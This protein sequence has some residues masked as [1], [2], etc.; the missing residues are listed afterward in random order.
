MCSIRLRRQNVERS[1]L[2]MSAWQLPD[3]KSSS[4]W[5]FSHQPGS[6]RSYV[7]SITSTLLLSWCREYSAKL[8]T[9]QS[10]LHPA[11]PSARV[12]PH[13]IPCGISGTQVLLANL[14]TPPC[15]AHGLC[16]R[17]VEGLM[18]PQCSTTWAAATIGLYS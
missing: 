11:A 9:L 16:D 6:E 12:F 14:M 2:R 8:L 4:S 5:T 15:C 1:L 10:L 7:K 17:C 3:P 13:I 18:V